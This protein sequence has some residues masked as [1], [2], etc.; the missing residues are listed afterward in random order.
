MCLVFAIFL[1]QCFI[2][3]HQVKQI[4][5]SAFLLILIIYL[6]SVIMKE[7]ESQKHLAAHFGVL[8]MDLWRSEIR[9]HAQPMQKSSTSTVEKCSN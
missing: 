8:Y 6:S 1:V 7:I 9:G 5:M 2:C 3:G 4:V